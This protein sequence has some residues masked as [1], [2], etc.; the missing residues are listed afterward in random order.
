MAKKPTKENKSA[1]LKTEDDRSGM[2]MFFETKDIIRHD[3]S[4][5]S[6]ISAQAVLMNG[7]E[8]V[9]TANLLIHVRKGMMSIVSDQLGDKVQMGMPLTAVVVIPKGPDADAWRAAIAQSKDQ[10]QTTLDQVK[11]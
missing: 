2:L 6:T 7:E 1:G 11:E 3:K 10:D 9:G 5:M 8:S 4:G